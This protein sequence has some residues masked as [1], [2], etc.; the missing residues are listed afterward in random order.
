MP[1]EIEMRSAV[2]EKEE[3]K[4]EENVLLFVYV[5]VYLSEMYMNGV[6]Q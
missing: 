1:C 5:C 6:Y 2:P 4:E 3:K